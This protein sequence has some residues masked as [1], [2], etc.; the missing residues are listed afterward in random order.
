MIDKPK[1]TKYR[2]IKPSIAKIKNEIFSLKGGINELIL[3]FGFV[4]TDAEHFVFVGDYF[5]VITR[6]QTLTLELVTYL[7]MTPEE[8][9][10]HE[11]LKQ[12][13]A[14]KLHE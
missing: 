13:Q 11:L 14:F 1:E 7:K 8:K 6:G 9:K 12:G 5:K 4:A 2:T 3:A 10:K